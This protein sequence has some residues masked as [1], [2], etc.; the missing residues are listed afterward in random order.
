MLNLRSDFA[1]EI[2]PLRR[3]GSASV[4]AA[5]TRGALTCDYLA[6]AK[7]TLDSTAEL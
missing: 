6:I 3:L 5:Q 7:A 2:T 4:A 1:L